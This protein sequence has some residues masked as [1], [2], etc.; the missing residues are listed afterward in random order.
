MGSAGCHA[1]HTVTANPG[2]QRVGP[3]MIKKFVEEKKRK[4]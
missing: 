1:N 3:V 2:V 4:R